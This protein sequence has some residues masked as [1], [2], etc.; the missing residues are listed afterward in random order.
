MT[1]GARAPDVGRGDLPTVD[2]LETGRVVSDTEIDEGDLEALGGD[3]LLGDPEV[4]P[5]TNAELRADGTEDPTVAAQEGVPWVPPID[6]PFVGTDEDRDPWVSAGFSVDADDDDEVVARVRAALE[7]DART[8]GLADLLEIRHVGRRVLL[9][10]VVDDLVDE[11]EVVDVVEQVADVGE[12]I[13]R[14]RSRALG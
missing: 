1:D 4:D 7:G 3:V 11:D 2:D 6:P 12:V 9:G 8:S 14:L 10:G 5:L 13:S